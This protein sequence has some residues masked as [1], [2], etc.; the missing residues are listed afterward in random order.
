MTSHDCMRRALIRHSISQFELITEMRRRG[1]CDGREAEMV[2]RLADGGNCV[3]G[4]AL[5]IIE[6]IVS[7]RN[8]TIH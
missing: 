1:F 6:I 4:V 7:Q 2:T 8:A 3:L 5:C